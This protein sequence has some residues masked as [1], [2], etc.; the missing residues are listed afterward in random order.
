MRECVCARAARV[1]VGAGAGETEGANVG[2][3]TGAGAD[4]RGP[5]RW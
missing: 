2:G 5:G 4:W 3:D 1:D